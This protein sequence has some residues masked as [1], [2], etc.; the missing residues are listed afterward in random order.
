MV[1]LRLAIPLLHL[2]KQPITNIFQF[3]DSSWDAYRLQV[4]Y[5]QPYILVSP[6]S[7]DSFLH[8]DNAKPSSSAFGRELEFL[9]WTAPASTSCLMQE[10]WAA[11]WFFETARDLERTRSSRSWDWL[12]PRKALNGFGEPHISRLQFDPKTSQTAIW[13]IFTPFQITLIYGGL[14]FSSFC[15][16]QRIFEIYFVKSRIWE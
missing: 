16:C 13:F 8:R 11:N 3:E 2:T 15:L 4:C 7:S 9:R 10:R 12:T 6:A 5:E 1:R 14:K